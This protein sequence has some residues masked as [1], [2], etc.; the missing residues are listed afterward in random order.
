MLDHFT[1][2]RFEW[3]TGRGAGSHEMAT[4]N[5]LDKNSTKAEWE[6]VVREI[7]RMWEQHDYSYDGE[8]FTVP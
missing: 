3:G 4:F 5:I 7:P 1:N 6:E 8:R 2:R